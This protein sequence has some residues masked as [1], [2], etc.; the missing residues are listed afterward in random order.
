[1]CVVCLTVFILIRH[2]GASLGALN[3]KSYISNHVAYYFFM[4]CHQY[5]LI[6]K[7]LVTSL[8]E[9]VRCANRIVPGD[10]SVVTTQS[11]K[12]KSMADHSSVMSTVH[13]NI[14]HLVQVMD[15]SENK[16]NA[17]QSQ[18]LANQVQASQQIMIANL[19]NELRRDRKLE[20]KYIY[21]LASS[22]NE[23]VEKFIL[24]ALESVQKEIQR[25]IKLLELL[26]SNSVN[27]TI[28]PADNGTCAIDDNGT[29][30]IGDT[31]GNTVSILPEEIPS[32]L[33]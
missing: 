3:L 32:V 15:C 6:V 33:K 30:A 14:S 25:H 10:K 12:R 23:N 2:V 16:S 11:K 9:N 21:K 4:L 22:T 26:E 29:S 18:I 27:G 17:L 13:P 24:T 31:D 7:G 20:R 19:N 1:M 28:L 5:P 8:P